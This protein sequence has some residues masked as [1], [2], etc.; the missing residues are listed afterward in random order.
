[1]RV[2]RDSLHLK[3]L[4]DSQYRWVIVA[5]TLVIQAV[6]VG[7]LVYCFALYTVPWLEEFNAS[8]RDVMITISVLQIAMGVLAPFAGRILDAVNMRLLVLLGGTLLGVGLWAL[9]HVSALWHIWLIYGTLMPVSTVLMGTLAS[10]TLVAKWF[11]SGRGMALGI[12]AIGT[13]VGG[14]ILP[15]VVGGWIETLGWRVSVGYL[16]IG[17]FA[18]ALPLTWWVLAR[19]PQSHALPS[20]AATDPGIGD[21]GLTTSHDTRVWTSREILTSSLFWLPFLALVPLNM[22]FSALQFNLAIFARDIGLATSEV[23]TLITLASFFM[24]A[25]KVAFGSLG[26]RVDHRFLYWFASSVTGVSLCLFLRADSQ[27]ELFA[28]VIFMGLSG[29]SILP[30]MGLIFAAR[31]GTASF[32][33]VMGF[34]MLTVM[35]GSLAPVLAGWCYDLTGSYDY[36]L[37]ALLGLLMPTALAMYR[38]PAPSVT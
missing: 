4:P 33:R 20:V 35:L 21:G 18:L 31:F 29:G 7:V 22:T 30:M 3:R 11:D 10:Q 17:V 37:W 32:G 12:S 24:V 5:Y 36:A 14:M 26:D 34:V 8:R 38:L 9:Q 16:S 27:S 28:A 2:L 15:L 25:G 23:A 1:L 6:S 13:N 19:V